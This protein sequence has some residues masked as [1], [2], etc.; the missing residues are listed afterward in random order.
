MKRIPLF[1]FFS[2]LIAIT[3]GCGKKET[4]VTPPPS[5][6]ETIAVLTVADKEREQLSAEDQRELQRI[7]AWLDRDLVDVLRDSGLEP[8]LLHDMK[9]YLNTMGP[10]FIVNVEYFN[11]GVTPSL[12]RGR[13]DNPVASLDLNYKLLDNRGALLTEWKDGDHSLK[14]GT[15]CARTLNRRAVPKINGYFEPR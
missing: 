15:Y 14:G 8:I 13:R 2:I 5:R 12:P 10:L 1:F 6:M 9:N 11:P 3:G 7:M 4:A